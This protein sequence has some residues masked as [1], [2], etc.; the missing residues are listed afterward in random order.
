MILSN[1]HLLEYFVDEHPN[2]RFLHHLEVFKP[3]KEFIQNKKVI[4]A[5]GDTHIGEKVYHQIQDWCDF[6]TLHHISAYVSR[7]SH[8]VGKGT[9]VH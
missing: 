7:F 9:V 4:I 3:T 5:I 8:V 1:N 6:E 2:N